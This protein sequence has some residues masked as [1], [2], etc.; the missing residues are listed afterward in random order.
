MDTTELDLSRFRILTRED[1]LTSKWEFSAQETAFADELNEFSP[2]NRHLRCHEYAK[3]KNDQ[4]ASDAWNLWVCA[5]ASPQQNASAVSN[6]WKEMADSNKYNNLLAFFISDDIPMTEDF[7]FIVI[8]LDCTNFFFPTEVNF[9]CLKL[10]KRAVFDGSTFLKSV[11]FDDTEFLQGAYFNNATFHE[12]V[13]FKSVRFTKTTN[14][15][16]LTFHSTVDFT[17]ASFGN[18]EE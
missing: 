5:H 14:F 13:S 2:Y 3:K 11:T 17:G 1:Y 4:L 9:E 10:L 7:S 12:H 16:N 18:S 8:H 15:S 6:A